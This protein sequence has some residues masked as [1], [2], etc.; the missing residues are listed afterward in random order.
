MCTYILYFLSLQEIDT[1]A[2]AYLRYDPIIEQAWVKAILSS[3]KDNGKNYYKVESK[4]LVTV[5][6]I[7]IAKTDHQPFISEVSSTYAGIGVLN[8][9]VIYLLKVEKDKLNSFR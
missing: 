7:V 3:L 4:Q 1:S 8:M 9:L 2:S 6:L 5:L